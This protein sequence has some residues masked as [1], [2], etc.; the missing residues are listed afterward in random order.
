MVIQIALRLRKYLKR[1]TS[2]V[3]RLQKTED[4]ILREIEYCKNRMIWADKCADQLSKLKWRNEIIRLQNQLKL[5]S[6][7]GVNHGSITTD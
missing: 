5:L 3:V 6:D 4:S 2:S 7:L 1:F